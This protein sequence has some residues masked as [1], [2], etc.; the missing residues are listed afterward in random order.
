MHTKFK[1]T[2]QLHIQKKTVHGQEA[3]LH[4]LIRTIM[5]NFR[6]KGIL[7]AENYNP[8]NMTHHEV[9]ERLQRLG[10][11]ILEDQEQ[12]KQ[13]PAT[14]QQHLYIINWGDHTALCGHG[15]LLYTITPMYTEAVFAHPKVSPA[16]M[17][18]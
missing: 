6:E 10:I 2:D 16:Q 4:E 8:E 15:Y 5:Q 1:D 14:V 7:A 9:D 13:A 11:S 17:Q 3:P 18:R 12:K